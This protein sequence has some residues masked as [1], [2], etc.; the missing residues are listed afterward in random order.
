[1]EIKILHVQSVKSFLTRNH[2]APIFN[3]KAVK[4]LCKDNFHADHDLSDEDFNKAWKK[5]GLKENILNVSVFSIAGPTLVCF[6]I[7]CSSTNIHAG[8]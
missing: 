4:K 1:M 6:L 5:L 3:E 2:L 7:I 8:P